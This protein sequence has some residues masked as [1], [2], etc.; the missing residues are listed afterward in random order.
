MVKNTFLTQEIARFQM[1]LFYRTGPVYIECLIKFASLR[2]LFIHVYNSLVFQKMITAVEQL[3][4]QEKQELRE[5]TIAYARGRLTK[6]GN[7]ELAKVL[8]CIENLMDK[9]S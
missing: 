9:K 4:E 1:D 7:G 3:S 8:W 6:Q 2:S 5:Q